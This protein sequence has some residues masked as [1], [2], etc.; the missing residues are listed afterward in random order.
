[1][2]RTNTKIGDVFAVNINDQ[3]KKFM[4]YITSDLTQLNSD[5][6][7]A[8]KTIYPIYTNPSLQ[9]IVSAEVEF[10]AHC[11]TKLGIKM[12]YWDKIGNTSELGG[13]AHVL[14][15]DTND[16]GRKL[17]EESIKVSEKWHIWHINDYDFTKVG[18]LVGDQKKAEIG[19][20]VTPDDIV[21]RMKTGKYDFIYPSFE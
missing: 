1:M 21:T 13:T 16:Y 7:R 3:Q 20:V 14:F 18:K 9:E 5:V 2:Q 17:G 10:Y 11:I 15:R 4:Q 12:G 19:V 8:F 6:I